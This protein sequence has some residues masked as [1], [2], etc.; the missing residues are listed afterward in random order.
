MRSARPSPGSR[1]RARTS[2][3][4]RP[5]TPTPDKAGRSLA[6]VIG[7]PAPELI[8]APDLRAA[9][10]GARGGVVLLATGSRFEDVRAD[11]ERAVKA[12]L[13]VVSTCEELAYPLLEHEADAEALDRLAR[14]GT[15]R[16]SARG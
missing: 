9:F 2:R 1:S 12:G 14:T 10:A 11:V 3:W 8:V 6:D 4:W 13:S 15:S 16:C 7:A 5:W